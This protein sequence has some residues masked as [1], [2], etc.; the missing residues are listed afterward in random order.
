MKQF[1]KSIAIILVAVCIVF[2]SFTSN[3]FAQNTTVHYVALGDSLAA[4]Q[5]SFKQNDVAQFDKGYVDYIA[6][7]L[8]QRYTV[9]LVNYGVSG[10]TTTDLVT[11]ITND[12]QQI[13]SIKQADVIT[14][15]AGANDLLKGAFNPATLQVDVT[16]V[17]SILQ[18]IAQNM[19]T[20]LTTI[21]NANPDADIYV[22]GYFNAFPYLSETSVYPSLLQAMSLLNGTLAQS[23]QMANVTFINPFEEMEQNIKAYLP[24]PKDIHPNLEGYQVLA[25]TIW[26]EMK[27]DA[28]FDWKLMN[29]ESIITKNVPL[30]KMW[31][32]K[33][34]AEV[35]PTTVTNDTIYIVD[36]SLE[37]VALHLQTNGKTITATPVN[38][39]R[40]NET[41]VLYIES[42]VKTTTGKYLNN[43]AMNFT[44]NEK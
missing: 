1:Q 34:N 26:S 23:S 21:K 25:N 29:E 17:P 32:I 7:Y 10:Y 6:S 12:P 19:V 43:T 20:I 35:D 39:Y 37:K 11:D 22:M 42:G 44:T 16:K 36:S 14:L 41:Y 38:E 4:G 5:T 40:P 31:T 9:D 24:N 8:Q 2:T 15:N 3:S 27:F 18:T 33:L 28:P 13:Q 30:N